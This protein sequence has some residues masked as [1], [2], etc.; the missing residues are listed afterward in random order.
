MSL[1]DPLLVSATAVPLT[2]Q[3]SRRTSTHPAKPFPSSCA[4]FPVLSSSLCDSQ[5][6][7]LWAFPQCPHG[8]V[9][10]MIWILSSKLWPIHSAQPPNI[11]SWGALKACRPYFL[12]I[13]SPKL[14]Y[15]FHVVLA[16]GQQPYVPSLNSVPPRT[17]RCRCS[18]NIHT[19]YSFPVLLTVLSQND[20]D[21]FKEETAERFQKKSGRRC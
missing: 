15:H 21:C 10:D 8:V 7:P 12:H 3:P 19:G 9:T 13:P 2:V 6:K 16:Q 17:H 18:I 1:T 11:Q 5:L 20:G 14:N 4:A